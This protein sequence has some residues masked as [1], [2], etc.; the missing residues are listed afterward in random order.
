MSSDLGGIA[1]I[2][3][4]GRLGIRAAASPGGDLVAKL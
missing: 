2:V 4:T 3:V 1:A